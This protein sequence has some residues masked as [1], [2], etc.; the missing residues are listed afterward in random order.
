MVRPRRTGASA[1]VAF[2]AAIALAA[3]LAGCGGAGGGSFDTPPASLDPNSPTLIA[4]GIAFDTAELE[5]PASRPFTLVFENRDSAS[6]NVSILTS[7]EHLDRVFDSTPFGGP[8]T[9]WYPVPALAP[10]RY[11]FVCDLHA[12]MVGEVTAR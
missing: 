2:A 1:A 9:R 12:N 5:V 4:E 3:A 6:H 8:G 10:G 11:K 7:G